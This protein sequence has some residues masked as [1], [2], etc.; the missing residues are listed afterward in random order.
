MKKALFF[1]I[2]LAFFAGCTTTSPVPKAKA[3]NEFSFVFITDIH[4]QPELGATVAFAKAID[5]ANTLKA[6]FVLTGGDLVYDV[7]RGN[8]SRS[9][10]LFQLYKTMSAK[11][12]MPVYN[13]IGN[14]ELFGIY[15]GSGI[16]PSDPDY[17]YGMYERYLGKTYYSF[18]HKG[19]H[20]IA[21]NS[22]EEKNKK[23]IG[24][25]S[26]D[27]VEWLKNDLSKI[28]PGTPIV[29]V[30]HIPFVSVQQQISPPAKPVVGVPNELWVDNRNEVLDLFKQHNL[31]LVLQ[32]H[33]H[34]VE[35]INVG[36]KTRFITGGAIAGRPSWRDTRKGTEGFMLM[37]IKGQDISW[38]YIDYGW[39][40]WYKP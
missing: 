17:K 26:K 14:H 3:D 30:T 23:Y 18:D 16:E 12:K 5:T 7:L 38:E 40:T 9:D 4:L 11:F 21:L 6:D 20:F 2:G 24:T 15:E 32:G 10:S 28:A 13:V 37:H 29:V 1:A 34:W 25:I 22:I 39:E 8:R 19:W 35:D 27:Q 33:L 31:K 36:G